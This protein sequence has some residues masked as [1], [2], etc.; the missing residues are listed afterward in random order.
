MLNKKE[1]YIRQ[2]GY[3]CSACLDSGAKQTQWSRICARRE[4]VQGHLHIQV[5]VSEADCLLLGKEKKKIGDIIAAQDIS[6]KEKLRCYEPYLSCDMGE[7]LDCLLHPAAGRYLWLVAECGEDSVFPEIRI[8]F[9]SRPWLSYLPESYTEQSGEGSF[10][11]RYLSIFQWIYYD[12]SQNIS[13]LPH[14]LYPA[15]AGRD[16]LE[17]LASWFGL[18]NG[19]SWD[20]RQLVWLVEN[21][22][23]LGRIRGTRKYMEEMVHLYTGYVPYIVEHH[24][25]EPY[26]TDMARARRLEKLYGEHP[27]VIT[28]VLPPEAVKSRQN[29]AA[30]RQ[31][32]RSCAPAYVE[33]RMVVLAPFI[34]LDCYSYM[35][36]NSRLSG[37][38][39]ASLKGDSLIPYISRIGNRIEGRDA[40]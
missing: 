3:L 20:R 34:F 33:C 4:G 8:F 40:R 15:F 29:M 26:K 16:T 23:R 19:G 22:E 9:E 6:M 30:L 37:S 32:I 38:Q 2:P 35:G 1:D 10:L 21:G 27:F 28:V 18:E 24:Q 13:E 17:W 39:G 5:Y 25:I 36:I 14:M 12:M 7:A 11:F 31:I